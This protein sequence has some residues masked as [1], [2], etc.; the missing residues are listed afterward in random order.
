MFGMAFINAIIFGVHGTMMKFLQPQSE[1]PK[2]TNSFLAG[3]TAGGIQSMIC[4]PMELVK[5]RMQVQDNATKF[6]GATQV[7][8]SKA[9]GA[10]SS[11]L[12]VVLKIYRKE[13]LMGLNRGMVATLCREIPAFGFYFSSYDLICQLMIGKDGRMADITPFQLCIAGGIS[14]TTS[15][16]VT[17]PIDVVKSRIQV[18]VHGRYRGMMDCFRAT[19]HKSGVVEGFYKGITTTVSRAFPVNAVTFTVVALIHR[20]S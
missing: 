1:L 2:L 13:G 7:M 5:S 20:Y 16:V 18:D 17:Y 12:D 8:S 9:K 3:A 10:Y 6:I 11:P 4:C 15:W 14:G 19:Y